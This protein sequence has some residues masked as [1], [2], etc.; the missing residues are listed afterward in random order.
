MSEFLFTEKLVQLFVLMK[1]IRYLFQLAST[2]NDCVDMKQWLIVQ[3]LFL[4]WCFYTIY[5][6][7][8]FD[9]IDQVSLTTSSNWPFFYKNDCID[10]KLCLIVQ[11][12]LISLWFYTVKPSFSIFLFVKNFYPIVFQKK[13][14]M[15]Q[16]LI[17]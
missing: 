7:L 17:L 5:L 6:F 9:K 11:V 13:I 1:L 2:K 14:N 16:W 8:C 12:L 15:K 3:V 10:M 4:S